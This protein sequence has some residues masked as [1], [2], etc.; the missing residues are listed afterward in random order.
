MKI[1]VNKGD[2]VNKSLIS[3]EGTNSPSRGRLYYRLGANKNAVGDHY[4]K[5]KRI[6]RTI[7]DKTIEFLHIT[8]KETR[9]RGSCKFRLQNRPTEMGKA[10]R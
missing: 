8:K 4:T 1:Q 3:V 2:T 5:Y 9:K 10:R 7:P 6:K